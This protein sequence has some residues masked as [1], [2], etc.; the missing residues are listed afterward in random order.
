MCVEID[1]LE[2][3]CTRVWVAV[4][5]EMDFWQKIVPEGLPSYCSS[6]WRLGHAVE[7]CRKNSVEQLV[8]V[9]TRRNW[10]VRAE[11]NPVAGPEV[12]L[13]RTGGEDPVP[14]IG[15]KISCMGSLDGNMAAGAAI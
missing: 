7:E 2:R 8:N 14:C 4:G 9:E 3:I 13:E 12:V 5:R 10:R 6:C 15:A 1:L 11:Q